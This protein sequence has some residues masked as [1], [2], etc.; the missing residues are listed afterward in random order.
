MRKA[1]YRDW[2]AD[3][4]HSAERGRRGGTPPGIASRRFS[5]G[6]RR[7]RAQNGDADVPRGRGWGGLHPPGL[8]S[9]RQ[10]D[11]PSGGN[12]TPKGG[13]KRWRGGIGTRTCWKRHGAGGRLPSIASQPEPHGMSKEQGT[14]HNITGE[15]GQ[16]QGGRCQAQAALNTAGHQGQQPRCDSLG[17]R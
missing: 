4:L 3:V 11:A 5:G 2:D 14:F 7:R 9:P 6:P 12:S 13:C 17:F 15:Q 1:H 8:A 10:K 16:Q